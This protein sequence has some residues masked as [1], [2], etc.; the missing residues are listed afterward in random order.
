MS[1]IKDQIVKIAV[2][3]AG[4]MGKN[5]LR[6]YD[7]LKNVELLGFYDPNIDTEN[8]KKLEQQ[9][10]CKAF[11][12]YEEI[13]NEVDAVSIC[14]PSSTHGEIGLKFLQ[15]KIHCLIEKPL[16]TSEKECLALIKAANHNNVKLLVGHIER[17]NPAIQQLPVLFGGNP[18]IL[19]ID[20]RRLSATSNRIKDVDVISDLMVHDLDI[21]MSLVNTDI[22]SV[23]ANGVKLNNNSQGDHVTALLKFENGA[24]AN[25]TASR[26]TPN[27]IRKLSITTDAGLIEVDYMNQ[28]VEVYLQDKVRVTNNDVAHFGDYALDI[29]MER[30]LVRRTEPLQ[31]ELS[32]FID[33]IKNDGQPLV[34]GEDGLKAFKLVR[35][36]QNCIN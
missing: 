31:V 5:H 13:I 28:S 26:I 6:V 16:A 17:F 1:N 11:H 12:S 10:N 7:M 23:K 15:A 29:V 21:V 3:G 30:V 27:T 33:I 22:S 20:A 2:I 32:H 24:I 35:Q 4:V 36:I 14:S 25:L 19:S 9:Y 18:K 8:I 34:S